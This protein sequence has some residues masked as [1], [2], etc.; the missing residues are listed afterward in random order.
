MNFDGVQPEQK[1]ST[2]CPFRALYLQVGVRRRQDAGIDV[3]RLRRAHTL[4]LPGFQYAQQLGLLFQGNVGDFVEEDGALVGQFKASNAISARVS[5]CALHMPKQFAFKSSFR[6]S[7]GIDRHHWTR[8][9]VRQHV[10]RARNYLFAGA[11]LAGDEHICVAGSDAGY[12]FEDRLHCLRFGDE[13]WP[14]L[15]LQ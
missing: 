14:A 3:L 1:I 6:Q 13:C 8:C 2:E 9:A 4:H 15:G 10:Q 5:K 11:V 12:K 7:T